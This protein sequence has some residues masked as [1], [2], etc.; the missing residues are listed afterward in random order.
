M[1][2]LLKYT[3]TRNTWG[4]AVNSGESFIVE[5]GSD[6]ASGM[7]LANY[8][9]KMGREVKSSSSIGGGSVKVG[10]SKTSNEWIIERIK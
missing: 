2:Y 5:Q 3:A 8:L 9:R 10:E 6:G 1:G 4:G 7:D